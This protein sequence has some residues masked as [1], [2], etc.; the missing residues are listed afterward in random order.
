MNLKITLGLLMTFIFISCEKT[1]PSGPE[2][3]EVLDD[4]VEGLSIEQQAQFLKG[5]IAFGEVFTTDRGLGPI[6]VSN[7]CASCH[8]GDGKGSLFVR[9]T[10]FGQSDTLG[11]QFLNMGGPQLQH[12]AIPGFEPE[13]LPSGATSSDLIAPAVTGLGFLDAVPDQALIT[14]SDPNDMDGDGISGRPHYNTV[15]EYIRLRPNSIEKNGRYISRFGKKGAAYNLLHQTSAAYNQDMGITSLFEPID[16]YSGLEVDP[17]VST[18]TVNDLV[19]YLKTLKEPI[20]RDQDNPDVIEGKQLFVQIDCAKCH[21]PTLRTGFSPIKALSEKD[22][23]PYSDML[24]HDMGAGLDDNYTEGYALT[25]EWKTPPL[26]GLGLSK[27]SQGGNYFLLHDGRA[28]SIEEA[29]LLHG[30]EAEVS[31]NK[32][33]DLVTEQKQKLI[34][35]LE[36]L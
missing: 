23:H 4:P 35:F 32:F 24:L 20:P 6:F 14:L 8:A 1:S 36:S 26:W 12:K 25:S 3:F 31:K 15:P 21:T 30:G 29:I 13:K 34:K 9:F 11:N 18:Q 17:E 7:Q 5:D 19:F 2:Q 22:F 16:P 28:M 10:R 27:E 33:M